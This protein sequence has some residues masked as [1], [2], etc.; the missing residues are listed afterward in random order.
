MFHDYEH[1][2]IDSRGRTSRRDTVVQG[3]WDAKPAL[4]FLGMPAGVMQAAIGIVLQPGFEQRLRDRFHTGAT[5]LRQLF[6]PPCV[7]V[8]DKH[9]VQIEQNQRWA[10]HQSAVP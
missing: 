8:V 3:Y 5:A 6:Q 1:G 7:R 4:E 10:R 9:A 2:V